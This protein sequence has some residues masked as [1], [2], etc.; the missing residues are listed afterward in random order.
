MCRTMPRIIDLQLRDD[1]IF[2]LS[3]THSTKP[4]AGNV[5]QRNPLHG[6]VSG[7]LG[8]KEGSGVQDPHA[9]WDHHSDRET[10]AF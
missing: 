1:V 7:G 4:A 9:S 2:V 5:R 8:G 10:E 6:Q 3:I